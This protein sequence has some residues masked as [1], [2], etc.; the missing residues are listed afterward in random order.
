MEHTTIPFNVADD[1]DL[2]KGYGVKLYAIYPYVIDANIADIPSDIN[3][4]Y[5]GN[6]KSLMSWSNILGSYFRGLI[7]RALGYTGH[8]ES[9]IRK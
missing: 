4:E 2:Y 3:Q 8:F 5:W 1:W 7:K 9:K 6:K